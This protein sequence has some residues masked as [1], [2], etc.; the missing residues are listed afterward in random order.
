MWRPRDLDGTG[1]DSIARILLDIG[2]HGEIFGAAGTDIPSPG[3][4]KGNEVDGEKRG[5]MMI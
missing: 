3:L 4:G 1:A 5:Q 2:S